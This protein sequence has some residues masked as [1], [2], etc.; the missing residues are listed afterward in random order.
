MDKDKARDRKARSD[1]PSFG[2]VFR[3]PSEGDE[4][5]ATEAMSYLI[6]ALC[7]ANIRFGPST[8]F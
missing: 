7:Q 6:D 3:L 1:E 4:Q 2:R 5:R 8:K